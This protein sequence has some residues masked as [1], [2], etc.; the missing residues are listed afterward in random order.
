MTGRKMNR[1]V[2][3]TSRI[4]GMKKLSFG[5]GVLREDVLCDDSIPY[6]EEVSHFVKLQ[7]KGAYYTQPYSF[8]CL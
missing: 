2:G 6:D 1:F 7:W 5:I 8:H 4:D 3:M